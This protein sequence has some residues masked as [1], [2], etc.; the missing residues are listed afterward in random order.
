MR[1]HNYINGQWRDSISEHTFD[2]HSPA[3]TGDLVGTFPASDARDV[4]EAVRAARAAFPQWRGMSF[5]RRAEILDRF[6]RL[7]QEDF[8]EL[9]RLMAREGGKVLA[10]SRADV[11]EGIHMTQYMVGR[12]RM[13]YGDVVPSEIAEKDS[14]MLRKPKGVVAAITPWNFPFAI[15]MWSIAPSLATGNTVVFK[16]S[17]ETPGCG[18]KVAEY[19]H[20]AGLPAGVFNM[21]HGTGDDAGW[22]LINHPE[23]DVVVFTGSYGVG[24]KIKETVAR[25]YRKM[26]ACE[27]GGK[28]AI[29]VFDDANLDL[30]VNAAVT[31]AFRTAGQRCSA[32]SRLIVQEGILDRF[33]ERFLA[34]ARRIRVGD[35]L[36]ERNFMGPVINQGAVDKVLRY[37]Q[38]ARDEGAQVLLDGGRLSG[39]GYGKGYFMSPFV[40]LMRHN[41]TSRVIR[42]EVFGPHVAI[43]PFKT[44]E[45]AIFI[46][47]DVEYGL[48]FSVI[49]EDY[50][51]ARRV[52]EECEF[53]LGYVNLPCIGAEVQLPFG[54][55]K[56]SGTGMP[57]AATLVDVV[58]HKVAWTV[59]HD[60]T[61]KLAQGLSAEIE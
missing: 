25:D 34:G 12:S 37:N 6:V 1:G 51:K 30:A 3:N 33:V 52:R 29:M 5:I 40:Y 16:P 15:P 21:V 20:E 18:Q 42:E 57:S 17:S 2:K 56:K 41:P 55:L 35:P 54:G 53:G 24:S 13:P 11:T 26:V 46:H 43:I 9:A 44:I 49:T 27:M 39:D 22:P 23:V 61:I 14:Y 31:S 50:R 8:E 10:E 59:N 47:N 7:V 38:I 28:N 48:T 32:A 4:E 19:L 36:D 58:T 45:E 60:Q